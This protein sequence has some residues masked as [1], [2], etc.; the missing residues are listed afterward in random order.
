MAPPDRLQGVEIML[1]GLERGHAS[2]SIGMFA[3]CE[4]PAP[5]IEEFR[6]H[7]ER[8]LG[9]LSR[10]RQKAVSAPLGAWHSVWADDRDFQLDY[11][12]RAALVNAPGDDRQ[13]FAALSAIFAQRIDRTR[14]L[15]EIHLLD[16]LEGGRFAYVQKCHHAMM[17]GI[18]QSIA[19]ATICGLFDDPS[20]DGGLVPWRPS[21]A[22]SPVRTLTDGLAELART[23]TQAGRMA[24]RTL[25]SPRRSF[26]ALAKLPALGIDVARLAIEPAPRSPLNRR[27]GP[28]R[29]YVGVPGDLATYKR[30]KHAYDATINDV[31]LTVAA[32]GLSALMQ[33]RG[34]EGELT[35]I[36]P[37]VPVSIRTVDESQKLTNRVVTIRP[38]LP[39]ALA[40]PV[41]RLIV[42]KHQLRQL[43][44][45]SEATAV[46]LLSR[47]SDLIPTP[48]LGGAAGRL[49]FS[50]R[51]FNVLITNVPGPPMAVSIAGRPVVRVY[52]VPPLVPDHGL[53]IAA[54]SVAGELNFGLIA[55]PDVIPE[56][57]LV[58]AGI[59]SDLDALDR[60]AARK[61]D[62]T[63]RSEPDPTET[64][65]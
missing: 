40:D 47:T 22:P 55:D 29:R 30:I 19:F 7:V 3:I 56:L 11:H 28:H 32:G 39:L 2:L 15:W 10:W 6:G 16:G 24:L 50:P 41:E 42:I 57:D 63:V 62:Q 61:H 1:L 44:A 14:P 12:V 53:A 21:P 46:E 25:T 13:L 49:N 33:A 35:E 58:A 31:V 54:G 23:S 36:R 60:A 17:D 4:G 5:G 43:K 59:A 65:T 20:A 48:L 37:L 9:A 64:L 26:G 52:P 8:H 27:L 38:R 18:S 45:S 34:L 51:L